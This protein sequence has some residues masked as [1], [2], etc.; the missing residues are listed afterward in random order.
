MWYFVLF[1]V[2][3]PLLTEK[4]R[5]FLKNLLKAFSNVRGIRKCNAIAKGMEFIRIE[6]NSPANNVDLPDYKAGQYYGNMKL[7]EL[8]S[9][10]ELNI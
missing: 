8:Y 4:E 9:I 2:Q 10:D 7:N 1:Q 5:D 6:T 3:L